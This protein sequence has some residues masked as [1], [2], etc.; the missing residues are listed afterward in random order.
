VPTGVIVETEES[1]GIVLKTRTRHTVEPALWPEEVENLR[2]DPV[3]AGFP[4]NVRA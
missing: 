2:C 1:Q 3:K 4:S